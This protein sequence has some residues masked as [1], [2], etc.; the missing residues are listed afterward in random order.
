MGPGMPFFGGPPSG[1]TE[2]ELADAQL[3]APPEEDSQLEVLLRPGLLADVEITVEELPN[4]IYIPAQAIFEKDGKPIVYVQ[5]GRQFEERSVTLLRRSE[6]TMVVSAG[7]KPG[8]MVALADPNARKGDK[9]SE[10]P[11][12]GPGPMGGTPA[13]G[14]S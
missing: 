5:S 13:A 2:K 4:A 9:S 10:K 7:L 11:G 12:G 1:F 8:E 14:K 6:A 3:P